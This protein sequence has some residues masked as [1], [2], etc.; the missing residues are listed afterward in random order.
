VLAGEVFAR[1]RCAFPGAMLRAS[2]RVVGWAP[3]A[4]ANRVGRLADSASHLRRVRSVR[5]SLCVVRSSRVI[6]PATEYRGQII[7]GGVAGVG[8][9]VQDPQCV[10][11][12]DAH[13]DGDH[14]DGDHHVI[15]PGTAGTAQPRGPVRQ[16]V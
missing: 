5:Q 14:A 4:S 3:H 11:R 9:G 16:L 12:R 10:V 1:K 6:R 15:P 7:G 13:S 8:A 2:N